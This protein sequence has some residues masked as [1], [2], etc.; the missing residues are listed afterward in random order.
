[1]AY[2]EDMMLTKRKGRIMI[3]SAFIL[4][5]CS[6]YLIVHIYI[7]SK[8]MKLISNITCINS[9]NLKKSTENKHFFYLSLVVQTVF[10]I[11]TIY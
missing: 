11:P 5:S 8:L 6:E 10:H 2:K 3:D 9:V 1:M 4:H 7:Q